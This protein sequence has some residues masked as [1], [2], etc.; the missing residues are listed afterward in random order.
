MSTTADEHFL[1]TIAQEQLHKHI[2]AAEARGLN[3][4][5][6]D[7][8][9]EQQNFILSLKLLLNHYDG[10][11]PDAEALPLCLAHLTLAPVAEAM[12]IVKGFIERGWLSQEAEL[13]TSGRALLSDL[14]LSQI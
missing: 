1:E 11:L 2:Q 9:F 4:A 3:Q 8:H 10:I 12:Q 5:E 13:T 7:A 6:L 14:D